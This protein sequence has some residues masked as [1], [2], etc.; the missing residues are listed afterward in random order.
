MCANIVI[1]DEDISILYH[2]VDY[3]T[4]I[5]FRETAAVN[6]PVFLTIKKP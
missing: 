1:Q 5:N 6:S 2:K 4:N 3:Y